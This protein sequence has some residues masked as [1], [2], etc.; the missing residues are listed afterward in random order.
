MFFYL[1][2]RGKGTT[3]RPKTRGK[4]YIWKDVTQNGERTW[5][6]V[7]KN[8]WLDEEVLLL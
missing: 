6:E 8:L 1:K 4:E 3:R 2:P 5:V 7:D